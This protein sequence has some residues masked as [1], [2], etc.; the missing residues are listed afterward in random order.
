MVLVNPGDEVL[1]PV[2]YRT[3]LPA[4]IVIAGGT[5]VFVETRHN[6]YVPTLSDLRAAVTR[7]TR[8]IV[9]NAPNNPTGA[10]YDRDTL[11]GMAQLAIDCGVWI[12]FDECYAAFAHARISIIR[13]SPWRPLHATVL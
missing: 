10:V 13:S 2:P 9:I 5:P 11:A 6:N 3:T 1:I 7:K 8:A 4:Q 12:I